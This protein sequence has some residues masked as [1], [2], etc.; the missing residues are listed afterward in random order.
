MQQ[1]LKLWRRTLTVVVFPTLLQQLTVESVEKHLNCQIGC[2]I[3][4]TIEKQFMQWKNT[5]QS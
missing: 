4:K 2:A 3:G 1:F 5:K